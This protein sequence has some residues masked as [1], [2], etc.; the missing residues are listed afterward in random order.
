MSG[1]AFA[2]PVTLWV[3]RAAAREDVDVALNWTYNDDDE[4]QPSAFARAY[5]VGQ[6]DPAQTELHFG[7]PVS[8]LLRG[9]PAIEAQVRPHLPEGDWNGL[10]LVNALTDPATGP[11]GPVPVFDAVFCL[12]GTFG[13]V[14]PSA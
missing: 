1:A 4:P 7:A 5:G 12:V 2:R 3:V 13:A 6:L 9:L 11:V 10:Y 14:T 8:G